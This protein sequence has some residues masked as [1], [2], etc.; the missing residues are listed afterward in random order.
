MDGVILSHRLKKCLNGYK[1]TLWPSQV[2][3]ICRKLCYNHVLQTPQSQR[4]LNPAYDNTRVISL[5]FLIYSFTYNINSRSHIFHRGYSGVAACLKTHF[6][7]FFWKIL[8]H[9]LRISF[10]HKQYLCQCLQT[11]LIFPPGSRKRQ[12]EGTREL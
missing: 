4:G 5:F 3:F 2:K 7:F 8:Q 12:Q 6:G 9:K 1:Y 11:C 10:F